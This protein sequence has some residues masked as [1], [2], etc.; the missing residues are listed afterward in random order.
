P[1]VIRVI[2]WIFLLGPRSGYLNEALRGLGG[3]EGAGFDIFSMAGMVLVETLFWLP[4][5]F[6]LM[7]VPLRSM[8][9][10]L[11]DAAALS[12]APPLRVLRSIT[13]RLALP[14]LLSVLLLTFV[15]SIQ[16][17]EIPVL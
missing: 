12:G 15:R 11:E 16:A 1:G 17:F 9:P 10:S 2:G 5:V 8:D 3:G 4:V 7:A 13:L 6:L 14:A